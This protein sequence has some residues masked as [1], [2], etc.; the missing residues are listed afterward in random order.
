MLGAVSALMITVAAKHLPGHH[1]IDGRDDELTLNQQLFN[2]INTLIKRQLIA[3]AAVNMSRVFFLSMKKLY[4]CCLFQLKNSH[5]ADEHEI[6]NNK[7]S[8][9]DDK[10]QAGS[11]TYIPTPV[12]VENW[13]VNR[14]NFG[15]ITA[16]SIDPQGNPVIFHRADRYWDAKYV[17]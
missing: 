16:V 11:T 9:F 7:I 15:Q 1:A 6:S 13:P 8:N 17:N 4:T 3:N 5:M 2:D 12:L 10:Q 14:H